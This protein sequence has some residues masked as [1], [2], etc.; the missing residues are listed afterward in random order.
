MSNNSTAARMLLF[1]VSPGHLVFITAIG[2]S[3]GFDAITVTFLGIYLL[4]A[5]LQVRHTV[6]S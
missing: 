2:M 5:L 4:V 3:Q 6:M 1:L